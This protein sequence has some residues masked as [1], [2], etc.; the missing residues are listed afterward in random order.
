[1]PRQLF[2]DSIASST[3]TARSRWTVICST[4]A[5]LTI[6]SIAVIVPLMA[7]GTLPD[8]HSPLTAFM[9]AEIKIPEMPP[10]GSPRPR[11]AMN[12]AAAP[13]TAPSAIDY[14]AEPAEPRAGSPG[15]GDMSGFDLGPLGTPG[16]PDFITSG[17]PPPIAEPVPAPTKPLRVGG[18]IRAPQRIF[19]RPLVYPPMAQLSRVEGDVILEAIIDASGNVGDIRILRSVPLLDAAAADAVRQWKYKPTLLNGVPVPVIMTITISF[20]LQD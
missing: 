20:R 7:T 1:V 2:D 3:R 8:V 16:V 11:P 4:V 12:P 19:S 6:I 14:T 9:P 17:G 10:A 5:H 18:V 15:V 13:T